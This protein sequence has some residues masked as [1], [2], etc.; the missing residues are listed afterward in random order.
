MENVD[1]EIALADCRNFTWMCGMKTLCGVRITQWH[2][3]KW[4][5]TQ[6]EFPPVPDINDPATKGCLL[7]MIRDIT[8]DTSAYVTQFDEG[9]AIHSWPEH[10]SPAHYPTEAEAIAWFIVSN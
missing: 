7:Q 1:I 9:W 6:S 3:N 5:A 4:L 2:L 10:P 8:N